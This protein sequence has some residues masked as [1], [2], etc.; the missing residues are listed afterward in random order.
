MASL[1]A[2][3]CGCARTLKIG[4]S[5]AVADPSLPQPLPLRLLPEEG[6][7]LRGKPIDW[8]LALSGGGLRS[9]F[10]SLG[11]LK[12]LYDDGVL[13]KVDIVS[14]VSGGGYT[15]YGLYANHLAGGGAGQP[16]GAASLGDE[17]FPRRLCEL[18]TKSDFVPYPKLRG[19]LWRKVPAG[20]YEDSLYRTFGRAE[21]PVGLRLP[22]FR[23]TM[24]RLEAPYLIQN[25][26]IVLPQHERS[27]QAKLVE[28][29]SLFYGTSDIGYLR[30][31]AEAGTAPLPM[32]KTTA[33][34]GAAFSPLIQ[35]VPLRHPQTSAP[36]F[37]AHDG[38]KSENLGAMALI[39]RGVPN[40]IIA[41][42]EHDPAYVFDAYRN[43]K[44]GL[45]LYG[46]NLEIEPIDR[47]LDTSLGS[48]YGGTIA[49]GNVTSLAIG[50]PVSTI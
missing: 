10:F 32:R 21:P 7:L 18:I 36:S 20:L 5:D 13:A 38:G 15:G 22:D 28:F 39:R 3:L 46:L 35:T 45:A 4:P 2:S 8:G 40:I 25:A 12:A 37:R 31:G 33:I 6:Q 17:V 41:D 24:A 30:W 19:L 42:A 48:P 16:F 44:A 50:K 23:P 29:T 9:A 43:L 11:V 26:T 49:K 14:T 47:H 1:V 27:W 34:S